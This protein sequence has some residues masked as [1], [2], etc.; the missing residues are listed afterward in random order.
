MSDLDYNS[1]SASA[2]DNDHEHA[3]PN[4]WTGPPT[5]W[6]SLTEQERGLAASL[7]TLRNGDLSIHL[8]N[9]H[10]LKRRARELERPEGGLGSINDFPGIPEEDQAFK[11]PKG[12]TAWPLPPEDVPRTGEQIGPIKPFE[13]YTFKAEDDGAPSRELEDILMGVTLKFAKERFESREEAAED[14]YTNK[15][16]TKATVVLEE[17]MDST[18]SEYH[19]SSNDEPVIKEDPKSPQVE[20]RMKPV[21]SA[22]DERSRVLL[23]PSIRH[24]LSKLDEVLIALHHARKTCH[25]YSQS[26]AGTTDDESLADTTFSEQ[27][28]RSPSKQPRG[29]P[30]KFANLPNRSKADIN[31][32]VDLEPQK[33][34]QADL[35]RTKTTHLGRPK[36][37]YER[38]EGETQQDYLIR[39][40]RIQKKPLPVFAPPAEM[41]SPKSPS[42]Q[43]GRERSRSAPARRATS[44]EWKVYRRKKLGLRDWSEVLGVAALVGFE[45]E[46]LERAARRCADL[47]GEAM[48]MRRLV[49]VPFAE[50]E[51]KDEFVRYEPELVPDFEDDG[52]VDFSSSSEDEDSGSDS[53]SEPD[54][55][56]DLRTMSIHSRQAVFCPIP[57]CPRRVHGF[58]D[59][60]AMKRHLQRGHKIQKE[61]FEDYILPSDEE[62]H[63]AVHIDGFL[64]PLKRAVPPRG[65]YKKERKKRKA[66]ES[67]EDWDVD[68]EDEIEEE[69]LAGGQGGEEEQTEAESSGSSSS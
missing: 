24:T 42:P 1:S 14:I 29:R 5:S 38:L 52:M 28:Q 50:R 22:D 60:Y 19:D 23:R 51:G 67:E 10:A 6:Q 2:S 43:R 27:G 61:D 13:E 4:R 44:G 62:M 34:D 35:L 15:G 18:G 45:S 36:K 69:V 20:A 17:D 55:K 41:K 56:P 31:P 32:F 40:A 68:V 59:T 47:F 9:A 48:V 58:R 16:K 30:R 46:V 63:G 3:R 57:A 49:E 25:R 37:V 66:S 33:P 21:V 65:R 64:K 53:G 39:I 12:W 11:P 26:D 8:F 7:D 54:I